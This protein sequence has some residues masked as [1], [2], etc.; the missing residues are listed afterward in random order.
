MA[1]SKNVEFNL[2][3]IADEIYEAVTWNGRTHIPIARI[4]GM[5]DRTIGLMGLTKSYS[6]GGWRIGYA[7][8]A[9]DYIVRM[10]K[11]QQH[12]M[13]CAGSFTQ[14]GAARALADDVTEAMKPVWTD[15]E[16]R[17]KFV[18]DNINAHPLLSGV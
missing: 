8:A 2:T 6:M 10:T 17:C 12:L 9:H 7:Y 16:S 4:S 11:I 13:T 3:V 15:W 18:T 14:L 1:D 5:E